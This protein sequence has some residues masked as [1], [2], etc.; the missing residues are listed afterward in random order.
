MNHNADHFHFLQLYFAAT[1]QHSIL[2]RQPKAAPLPSNAAPLQD[3][4]TSDHSSDSNDIRAYFGATL[5]IRYT[6]IHR[7][8]QTRG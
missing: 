8:Q 6:K 5:Q 2:R 3:S 1:P 7:R 4:S